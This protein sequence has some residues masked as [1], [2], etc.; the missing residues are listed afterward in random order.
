VSAFSSLQISHR[1][2]AAFAAVIAIIF[3]SSAVLYDRLRVI[4]AAKNLR[5]HTTDVLDTLEMAMRAMLD[6]ETGVRGY[7]ISGDEKF[8]EPYH[9]G[10]DNFSAAMRR[11]KDLTSDNPAQQSR[12]DE[13]NELAKK[14]QLEI[15]EPEIALMAKP[16]TRDDARALVTSGGGR[17]A[18]DLI[19]TKVDAIARV[20]DD[21]LAK[22]DVVQTQA[23]ATA[24]AMTIGGAASL[25]TAVLMGVLLT[26]GITMP[27]TRM[28]S[29]MAALAKGDTS[30][31]VPGVGRGDEIGAM[32]VAV[33]VF[34]ESIIERQ[35]T[36][37]ELAHFNR[38]ETMGQLTASIAHEVNQPI[39]ATATNAEAALNW[40]RGHPPNLDKVR[41]SLGHIVAD[42]NRAGDIISRIRGLI[43]KAPAPRSRLDLNEA[44]LD[45]IALVRT[46][47]LRHG[48]SL[49]TQLARGLP[50]IEG[51]R[52]QLQQVILN[53]I[54]NAVEAM[55]SLDKGARELQIS[56]E[57]DAAG[58]VLV[59]V[60]DSGPGLDSTSADRAFESF[61]TTKPEG[62][63]M[64]LAICRSI[65]TAHGGRIWA[66]AN[67]P[68]GAIL[69][70]T[71]PAK[72]HETAAATHAGQ[73]PVG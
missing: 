44:V 27:I 7:L 2:M 5:I 53:L 18:M 39:S 37:A 49:Q 15:A 31:E 24:Y 59:T 69:Q 63:G 65:I 64:G 34:K 68:R 67:Q 66:T 48:V 4:E 8:L 55:T 9:N 1:L 30:I 73:M 6:Q 57:T 12:L 17:T 26:R 36:Q 42:S 10:V 58:G 22:R 51:E 43:K 16:E 19:R 14:W 29:A 20:E 28:T 56:T 47:V 32:A 60:R 46:E 45:V 21:L 52:V 38:I 35:R 11:I 50:L 3:V 61:Y 23:Y 13:L 40:L 54:L 71:L 41:E 25:I 33:Q 70:F 72:Q 62:I